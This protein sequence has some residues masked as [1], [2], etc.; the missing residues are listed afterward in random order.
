[1]TTVPHA[2]SLVYRP[3]TTADEP[4]VLDLLRDA[5]GS[6]PDGERSAD[7]LHWKHR[8]NPFGPSPSMVA[9][10]AGRL[11]GV[12][13]LMRWELQ[14]GGRLVRAVR[15]VDTATD[16]GYRGR[17]IFRE[18]TLRLLAE[19]DATDAADLVF[20]TPNQS[21]RPGYLKM[22]WQPVGTL[23]VLITPVRPLRFLAGVRSARRSTAMGEQ[24]S[25]SPG[26]LA[27]GPLPASPLPTAAETLAR[28]Q[29]EIAELLSRAAV[30]RGLHTRRTEQFLVWR[31]G[32]APGLDYRCLTLLSPAGELRGLAFGRLR[33]R[34]ALAE[35]TLSDLVVAEG[36]GVAARRLLRAARRSGADHVAVHAPHG[37]PLWRA[38]RL[39][40]YLPVPR[41]G[42][43][44]VANPRQTLPVDPFDVRAW[45]LTLGDL[46]V[47]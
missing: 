16:P 35:L 24:R 15:A 17:G 39:S 38:A 5:L 1:M 37:S 36:D 19:L 18:L 3:A 42:L 7:F 4:A 10:D 8:D 9:E 31:Y 44:L 34:G 6:G 26:A 30:P 29:G 40:G 43:G 47:F 2:Q 20:N 22:G 33:H 14:T 28:H 25:G 12:R 32:Q 45:S 13:L 27:R 41:Y 11:V 21:S 23:P 46:E